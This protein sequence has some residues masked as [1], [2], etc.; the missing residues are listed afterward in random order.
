MFGLIVVKLNDGYGDTVGIVGA[1]A[2]VQCKN[3][4]GTREEKKKGASLEY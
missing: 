1:G 3:M 2:V 4:A